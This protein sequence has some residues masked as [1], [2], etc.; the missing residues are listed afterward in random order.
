MLEA[1]RGN[2]DGARVSFE[3]CVD[4][5]PHDQPFRKAVAELTFGSFLRRT[6]QRR[7]A[8]LHLSSARDAFDALRAAPYL[9]TAERELAACGLTPTRRRTREPTKLTPQ[10]T[11]IVHLATKGYTNKEI[12]ADLVI[13]VRTVEYHLTNAYLKL[14]VSSRR[15]LIR[16]RADPT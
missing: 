6:G 7:Q 8:Q 12:A 1:A 10:E 4:A 14:G 16:S 2:H 9:A 5:V 15:E 13:S 3:A 11:A